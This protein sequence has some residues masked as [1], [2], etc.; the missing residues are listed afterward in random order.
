M[1]KSHYFTGAEVK[2]QPLDDIRMTAKLKYENFSSIM[3]FS[4]DMLKGFLV[5]IFLIFFFLMEINVAFV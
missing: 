2:D 3:N 1:Q 4:G 5:N